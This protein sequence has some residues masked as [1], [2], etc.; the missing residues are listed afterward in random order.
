MGN[1]DWIIMQERVLIYLYGLFVFFS[2]KKMACEK[3][4]RLIESSALLV[5]NC[6]VSFLYFAGRSL[7]KRYLSKSGYTQMVIRP[8]FSLL[9]QLSI[10]SFIGVVFNMG[11]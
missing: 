6:F 4:P 3:K 1:T 8:F 7:S 11:D 2:A 10:S 9:L 5:L